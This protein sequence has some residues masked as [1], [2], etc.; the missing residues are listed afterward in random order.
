M[1]AVRTRMQALEEELG[2][3]TEQKPLSGGSSS[4]Q[5][6]NANDNETLADVEK[7]LLDLLGS[8]GLTE[9]TLDVDMTRELLPKTAIQVDAVSGS[10]FMIRRET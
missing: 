4:N 1:N 7:S 5:R 6:L 3:L 10:F 8:V 2:D 9:N